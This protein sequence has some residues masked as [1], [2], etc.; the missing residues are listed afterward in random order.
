VVTAEERLAE[1]E[2]MKEQRR[3][4]QEKKREE[5]RKAEDVHRKMYQKS[6]TSQ[7][8]SALGLPPGELTYALNPGALYPT[9]YTP[10]LK[11]FTPNPT[12]YTLRP[13]S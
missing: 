9:P 12:P 1:M 13:T 10:N 11:T 5:Q 4:E 3:R 8:A 7:L 6:V 2:A